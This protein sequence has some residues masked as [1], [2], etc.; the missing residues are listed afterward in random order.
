MHT[1]QTAF[2][3]IIHTTLKGGWM[4]V[5]SPLFQFPLKLCTICHLSRILG[6]NYL[7]KEPGLHGKAVLM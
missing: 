7:Q 4:S 3:L 6:R 5:Q 2:A 1:L